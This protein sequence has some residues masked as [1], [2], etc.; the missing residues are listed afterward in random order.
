MA[1]TVSAAFGFLLAAGV[2]WPL[3]FGLLVIGGLGLVG[4]QRP[5]L[6]LA[7]F[8]VLR[9]LLDRFSENRA[10]LTGSVS[11]NVA[12]LLA[13][14]F[15]GVSVLVLAVRRPP[16]HSR[17]AGSFAAVLLVSAFAAAH[18]YVSLRSSVGTGVL[19]S[20]LARLGALTAIYILAVHVAGT[21]SRAGTLFVIV[22]LAGVVPA[23]DGLYQWA[24][25][26]P[27]AADLTIGRISGT[28]SGPNPFGQYLAVVALLLMAIPAD[29]LQPLV[30]LAA[31]APVLAA[32]VG[33]FSRSGWILFAAGALL[34]GWKH[35]R[36]AVVSILVLCVAL[37]TA[38]PV[39]RHRVISGD[40]RRQAGTGSV[41]VPSSFQWRMDTWRA[42]MRKY[43]E[44][45]LLGFGLRS[46]A[47]VNPRQV[48]LP[49][50]AQL[51]GYDPHNSVVKL[52]VEGGPALL[53]AWGVLL[54]VIIRRMRSLAHEDWELAWASR[55]LYVL[56]AVI[57]F[58]GLTSDDPLVA[59]AMLG[60]ML[61]LTGAVEGAHEH[62]RQ[63]AASKTTGD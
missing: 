45:P 29:R 39:L 43:M 60:G 37:V 25:G 50:Q 30:R 9:P 1:V 59:T 3:L 63:T 17:A 55:T 20:E 56:W 46:A 58:V 23:L 26:I 33:T 40:L 18:S 36:R 49:G 21:S 10:V 24:H 48:L 16:G 15:I 2:K 41:E 52:L 53:L 38:V 13:I 47:V 7:L 14:V 32:L 12:G 4:L 61:A 28:F 42:L 62:L 22:G 6:F 54:A 44:N 35:R 31:I 34:L 5:F 51:A 57:V 19:L 11:I 27:V 8:L